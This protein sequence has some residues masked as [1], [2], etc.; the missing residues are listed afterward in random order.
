MNPKSLDNANGTKDGF[1]EEFQEFNSRVR[2]AITRM[3]NSLNDSTA[4]CVTGAWNAIV[5]RRIDMHSTMSTVPALHKWKCKVCNRKRK[6]SVMVSLIGYE[7]NRTSLR[8]NKNADYEIADEEIPFMEDVNGQTE[9]KNE[10]D[11]ENDED[12]PVPGVLFSVGPRCF[13][14]MDL[15]HEARHYKA[16]LY[17]E[18]KEEFYHQLEHDAELEQKHNSAQRCDRKPDRIVGSDLLRVADAFTTKMQGLLD[19]SYVQYTG[20]ATRARDVDLQ[21]GYIDEEHVDF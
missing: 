13:F 12:Q 3:D 21:A 14:R 1:S 6:C 4:K 15:Y 9:Y 17:Q 7:Y 11:S 5:R 8:Q 18:I 2:K 10:D 20:I 19:M 16:Q